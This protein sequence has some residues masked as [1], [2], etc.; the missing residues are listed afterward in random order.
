[1]LGWLGLNIKFTLDSIRCGQL[2]LALVA[3]ATRLNVNS[4]EVLFDS[5]QVRFSSNSLQ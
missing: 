1:M 3:D 2:V 5:L 4:F